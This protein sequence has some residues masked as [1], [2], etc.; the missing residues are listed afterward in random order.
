MRMFSHDHLRRQLLAFLVVALLTLLGAAPATAGVETLADA[1]SAASPGSG[2]D[3]LLVLDA[4]TNYTGGLTIPAGNHCILG[5]GAVVN[6]QGLSVAA[7]DGVILDIIGVSF[8][9][10]NIGVDFTD[11]SMGHVECCNFYNNYDGLR[12][13]EGSS[14]TLVSCNF[15]NNNHY[16]VYRHEYAGVYNAFNNA[17]NNT[18]ND[19]ENISPG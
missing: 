16:G 1:F 6:L 10:G 18:A 8:V 9:N 19:Y 14:V 13:W 2:Y 3:T 4:G 12:A 11:G 17:W 7:G 15:V 5:N